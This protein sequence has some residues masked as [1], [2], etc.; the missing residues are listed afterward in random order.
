MELHQYVKCYSRKWFI[1]LIIVA[2]LQIPMNVMIQVQVYCVMTMLTAM[3]LMAVMNVCVKLATQEMDSTV[4]VCRN[5][6]LTL[7]VHARGLQ[8]LVC[9]CACVSPAPRVLPL[10]AT[11]R[12]T[13][14]TYGFGAIWLN[15]AFSLKML[16]SKVMA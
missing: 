10:R 15:M 5:T 6:L 12:P 1:H 4:L 8:Y 9:V 3:T 16:C 11:E 13:E 7:G 14:G 2:F